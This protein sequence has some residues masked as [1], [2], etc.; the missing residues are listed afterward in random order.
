[1]GKRHLETAIKSTPD[2]EVTVRWLP[3]L[4][5]NNIPQEGVEKG[6]TPE[7]RVPPRMR[8]AGDAVGIKFTG[9]TD[10]YPNTLAAHA[11]LAYAAE[12]APEKQSALQEVLFRHYFTDG[13]YPAG[14]N[15]SDAA[16]EVGLDGAQALSYAEAP[17]RQA[18]AAAA[19]RANSQRGISGV[20]FFIIN[21]K[22]E[23]SGA[24]PPGV[25]VD[26][27]KSI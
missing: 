3:F 25:F 2:A 10:R 26:I 1:V 27:F 21:G 9:L 13:R 24:Q 15:L 5:R 4:L 16:A 12:T 6:G 14:E 18:E 23:F 17:S 11:L 19:A 8:A 20:P 22:P 7:S